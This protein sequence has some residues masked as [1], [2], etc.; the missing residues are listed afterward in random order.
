MKLVWEWSMICALLLLVQYNDN[1][2]TDWLCSQ[3]SSLGIVGTYTTLEAYNIYLLSHQWSHSSF[4]L[5]QRSLWRHFYN[6]SQ[7]CFFT[8]LPSVCLYSLHCYFLYLRNQFDSSLAFLH[9]I[10]QCWHLWV[11]HYCHFDPLSK[12]KFSV[13]STLNFPYVGL[14]CDDNT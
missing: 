6:M 8:L 4:Y 10:V 13:P 7:S 9:V 14:T 1:V 3:S 12:G 5:H 11:L 2:V